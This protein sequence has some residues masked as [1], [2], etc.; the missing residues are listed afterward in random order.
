YRIFSRHGARCAIR[1]GV[2]HEVICGRPVAMTI[3][4]RADDSSVQYPRE[5][6]VFRLRFPFRNDFIAFGETADA[7][8]IWIRGAAS[9]AGIL[10]S[11]TFLQGKRLLILHIWGELAALRLIAGGFGAVGRR[12]WIRPHFRTSIQ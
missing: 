11:I 9:P 6:L 7:Q 3:E 12:A 4:Q 5:R 8:S 10:R 1:F 2:L